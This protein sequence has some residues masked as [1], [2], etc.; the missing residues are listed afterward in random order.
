MANQDYLS[1]LIDLRREVIHQWLVN[2]AEHCGASLAQP[3]PHEGDCQWP[4]PSL[5]QKLG[6][7]E[8]HSYILEASLTGG[9]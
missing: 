6:S 5:I 1:E 7:E 4:L 2:H 3:F 8:I 9:E